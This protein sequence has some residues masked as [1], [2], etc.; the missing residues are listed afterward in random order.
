M[1]S[2]IQ[3]RPYERKFR[4]HNCKGLT[5][6]WGILSTHYYCQKCLL[7]RRTHNKVFPSKETIN[8]LKEA[9]RWKR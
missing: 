4:C 5:D 9:G 6:S 3:K 2:E 1:K 8:D 7:W